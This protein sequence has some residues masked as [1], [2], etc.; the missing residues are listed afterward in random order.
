MKFIFIIINIRSTTLKLQRLTG[1]DLRMATSELN[2]T[3]LGNEYTWEICQDKLKAFKDAENGQVFRSKIFK[4]HGCKWR[5]DCYPMGVRQDCKGYLSA[6][7]ICVFLL[8][9]LV[10]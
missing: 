4:H 9:S 8:V 3:E 6:F 1:G 7:L 5:I 10:L 2:T